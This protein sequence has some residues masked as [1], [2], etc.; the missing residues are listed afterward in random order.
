MR[1]PERGIYHFNLY[2]FLARISAVGRNENSHCAHQSTMPS[3]IPTGTL[4][5]HS[6]RENS[7]AASAREPKRSAFAF[8]APANSAALNA[9]LWSGGDERLLIDP[10][11]GR[12]RYGVPAG[13]SPREVWLA[14][15]TASPVTS[16]G[17]AAAGQAFERIMRRRF[18]LALSAWFDD[19]RRRLLNLFDTQDCDVIFAASGTQAEFLALTLAKSYFSRPLTNIVVAP[20]ETG[21]GVLPAADG[22]HFLGTSPFDGP[23]KRGERLQGLEGCDFL[24]DA[25]ELRDRAGLPFEAEYVDTIVAARI[26]AHLATGRDVL[27]HVL[28]CSKTGLSG[29]TRAMAADIAAAHPGRVMVVVDACQLRCEPQQ[30]RSDLAAGFAVMLTGSKFGGGPPFA[31]ALLLPAAFS[32]RLNQIAWP[33]GLSAHSAALDWPARLRARVDGS[34]VA[35]ANIGLGLRWECALAELERYFAIDDPLRNKVAKA[36]AEMTLTELATSPRLALVDPG[37]GANLK[38]RTIFPIVTFDDR[39]GG[40]SAE[41]LLN[42]MRIPQGSYDARPRHRRAFHLGQAVEIGPWSG[43]RVCLGAPLVNAVADRM[44]AGADFGAAFKLLAEDLRELF[45]L[46]RQLAAEASKLAR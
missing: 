8:N 19:L 15:S 46:W 41:A 38:A 3:A 4:M 34:F 37:F 13:P 27:L 42:Q 9:Y 32:E 26:E 10:Q 23:I 35:N 17:Y 1:R 43:L 21:R 24:V 31:G 25:V 22:R 6:V 11:S 18:P 14:S 29:P 30:I 20:H 45:E 44:Q 33:A 2:I 39:G 16:R 36:F 28:D 5:N 7:G 12:N 40:I